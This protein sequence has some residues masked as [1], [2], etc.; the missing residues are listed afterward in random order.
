MR[1]GKGKKGKKRGEKGKKGKKEEGEYLEA[2]AV[3]AEDHPAAA[4]VV[5]AAPK[6]KWFV[7]RTTLKYYRLRLLC[8]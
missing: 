7:A 2:G 6:A 4:A 5:F 3:R 8:T 1:R